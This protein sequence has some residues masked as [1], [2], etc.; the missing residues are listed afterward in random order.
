MDTQE[1]LVRPDGRRIGRRTVVKG[2]VAT[3]W[4]V[5]LV[6]VVAAPA[7]AAYVSGKP[8]DLSTSSVVVKPSGNK[9]LVVDASVINSGPSTTSALN[10]TLTWTSSK[11]TSSISTVTSADTT[12]WTA[13]G[14]GLTAVREL[15]PSA[16]VRCRF[17]VSMNNAGFEGQL[18]IT[19]GTVGGK[20]KLFTYQTKA[21]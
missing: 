18:T 17:T 6:Q 2:A 10:V 13:K 7:F 19:I 20:S 4:T 8:A 15:D 11:G 12:L 14:T 1:Q 3:A 5:P 16:A 9:D 21:S